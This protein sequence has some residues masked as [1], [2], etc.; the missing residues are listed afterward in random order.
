MKA[1]YPKIVVNLGRPIRQ[2]RLQYATTT[3]NWQ[4][5]FRQVQ[6]QFKSQLQLQNK[7][8][9]QQH[10]EQLQFKILVMTLFFLRRH[11]CNKGRGGYSP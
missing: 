3:V 5:K 7:H 1:H 4:V 8:K 2:L 10:P 11:N 6:L 9:L